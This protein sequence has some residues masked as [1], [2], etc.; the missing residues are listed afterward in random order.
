MTPRHTP[1]TAPAPLP[2]SSHPGGTFVFIYKNCE[3]YLLI[4]EYLCILAL[5]IIIQDYCQHDL[6]NRFSYIYNEFGL[7]FV[8]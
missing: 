5:K 7:F 3:F 6:K 8:F 1:R 2:R 4:S